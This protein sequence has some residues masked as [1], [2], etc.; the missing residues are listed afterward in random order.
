MS[1]NPFL[2]TNG[3]TPKVDTSLLMLKYLKQVLIFFYYYGSFI[4]Y[5]V[6]IQMS[7]IVDSFLC[8]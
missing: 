6:Y 3:I 1:Y 2:Q 5:C 8:A 4:L 7:L